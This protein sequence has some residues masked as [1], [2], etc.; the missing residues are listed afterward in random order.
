[1]PLLASAGSETNVTRHFSVN[2]NI[3]WNDARLEVI[4]DSQFLGVSFDFCLANPCSFDHC[5]YFIQL[6]YVQLL[7]LSTK[8]VI[9]Y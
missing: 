7:L 6:V 9:L 8:E 5:L 2:L 3:D 4:T 1:M